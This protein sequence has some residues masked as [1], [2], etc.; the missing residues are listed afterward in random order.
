MHTK[1]QQLL[2]VLALLMASVFLLQ[3]AHAEGDA[4]RGE[5]LAYTC[6]GCH[7]IEGYRNAYPS[8]RVP[9]LGGQKAA[10]LVIALRGYRDGRRKHPTMTAQSSS[11]TDQEIDDVAAY[12]ASIGKDTVEQGGSAGGSLEQA[13]PCAACHGQN[14]IS[15]SPTWPTLAGQHED[16]LINALTQY[17]D[18][19]RTDPTM[20]PM[21]SALTDDDIK[22]LARYFS[23]LEGLE[24]TVAE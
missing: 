17:R 21:A 10:Y 6:L 20:V 12:L 24:T 14:G 19:T 9:K 2:A 11:L 18:G 3:P 23:R 13:V 1:T 16:Y 5:A 8:F 7:G 4:E 15:M 22:L